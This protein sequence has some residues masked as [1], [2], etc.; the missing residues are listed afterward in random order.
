MDQVL[1]MHVFQ[2]FENLFQ[3]DAT[4]FLVYDGVLVW[5][6]TVGMPGRNFISKIARKNEPR[7]NVAPSDDILVKFLS[8][9]HSFSVRSQTCI[10]MC[11][12]ITGIWKVKRCHLSDTDVN[13]KTTA[14]QVVF[15]MHPFPLHPRC[16]D[17]CW[18]YL[19]GKSSS[20][21]C[22]NNSTVVLKYPL[23]IQKSNW[24]SRATGK[25]G[26][27]VLFLWLHL[28]MIPTVCDP[29]C[30][31]GIGC[32]RR[33]TVTEICCFD[34][35]PVWVLKHNINTVVNM[36]AQSFSTPANISQ[37]TFNREKERTMMNFSRWFFARS[38][39][40]RNFFSVKLPGRA[41]ERIVIAFV[42]NGATVG[43]KS[44]RVS[45]VGVLLQPSSVIPH[46]VL[47]IQSC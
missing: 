2:A 4:L 13:L 40:R 41:S 18:C 19:N 27:R 46:H 28:E 21:F 8:D 44:C 36:T 30:S 33:G 47:V 31:W 16:Q 9:I 14:P 34:F 24:T 5:N 26:K 1:W 25:L 22:Q 43:V 10:W 6:T 29:I 23:Q 12:N 45:H 42:P 37:L 11:N 7:K 32:V 35:W 15:D 20:C 3:D 39:K 17:F 38:E